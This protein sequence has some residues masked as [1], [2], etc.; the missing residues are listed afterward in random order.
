M[1]KHIFG[2]E[3]E[4]GSVTVV[5]VVMLM[6]LTLIGIAA[7]RSATTDIKI[8][9]NQRFFK[10]NFLLAEGGAVREAMEVGRGNYPVMNIFIR[11][12][13]ADETGQT[14]GSD[15][16]D[17]RPHVVNAQPYNFDL[18]YEGVFLPPKGYSPLHCSRYDYS[19]EDVEFQDPKGAHIRVDSRF[20]RIGPKAT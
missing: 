17:P 20:F 3:R 11:S 1:K 19:A 8:A 9:A 10:R 18:W 15:L 2:K 16:P 4:K 14:N 5:A 13:L 6:V 12:Q 7:S